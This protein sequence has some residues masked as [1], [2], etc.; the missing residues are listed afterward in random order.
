MRERLGRL[1]DWPAWNMTPLIAMLALNAKRVAI[2]S[3]PTRKNDTP[4][5]ITNASGGPIT[6]Q[7]AREDAALERD[8]R[9]RLVIRLVEAVIIRERLERPPVHLP[10]CRE[11]ILVRSA[12][13]DLGRVDELGLRIRR[14]LDADLH[15]LLVERIGS[16]PRLAVQARLDAVASSRMPVVSLT[17]SA[18]SS[19]LVAQPFANSN[20][21]GVK[22]AGAVRGS[23]SKSM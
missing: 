7:H 10:P 4:E 11:E 5:M 1:A 12:L 8:D 23:H 13:G 20:A 16:E 9:T 22:S 14:V 21:S 3:A 17:T 19:R 2:L 18:C 6:L 15:G